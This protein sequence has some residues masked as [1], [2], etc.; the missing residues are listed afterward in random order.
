MPEESIEVLLERVDGNVRHL[1]VE[2]D[3]RAALDAE[4]ADSLRKRI[5]SLET[6]RTWLSGI[7]AAAGAAAALLS[8]KDILAWFLGCWAL[9]LAGCVNVPVGYRPLASASEWSA[10]MR[11]VTLY[12]SDK[13]TPQCIEAVAAGILFWYAHGVTYV[14]IGGTVPEA[15]T[16]PEE[17]MMSEIVVSAGSPKEATHAA[18]TLQYRAHGEMLAARVVFRSGYCAPVVAA[19]ELGHALGLPDVDMPGNVMHWALPDIGDD[20]AKRQLDLVR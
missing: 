13:L 10:N 5:T 12:V 2:F 3:K 19:H 20:V 6:T 18:A 4:V 15:R 11:P 8:R 1:R 9:M 7:V 16:A 14:T 17:I